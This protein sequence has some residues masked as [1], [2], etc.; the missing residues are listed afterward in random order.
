MTATIDALTTA[1]ADLAR[2]REVDAQIRAT[3][4]AAQAEFESANA[5]LIAQKTSAKVQLTAA[6]AQVRAL[7]LVVH[8]QTGETKPADGCSVVTLT[9]WINDPADA[10]AWARTSLPTAI[11]EVLDTKVLDKVA[12]TGALPFATKDE[13]QAVRIASDLSAYMTPVVASEVPF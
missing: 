12:S 4:A 1:L 5:E 11:S 8:E 7:A 9:R 13:T 6:E 3:L 2:A 10:M